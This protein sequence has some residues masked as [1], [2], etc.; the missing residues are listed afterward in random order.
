MTKRENSKQLTLF[1]LTDTRAEDGL[2]SMQNKALIFLKRINDG[3]GSLFLLDSITINEFCVLG[4]QVKLSIHVS[5]GSSVIVKYKI[6]IEGLVAT[7]TRLF[8]SGK[9]MYDFVSKHIIQCKRELIE[10]IMP[11]DRRRVE[12]L[13][14]EAT[15]IHWDS[16]SDVSVEI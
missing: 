12:S 7:V 6:V 3:Y 1:D 10:D 4:S 9:V 5:I 15:D 2:V 11:D 13:L 16:I 14:V 8:Y